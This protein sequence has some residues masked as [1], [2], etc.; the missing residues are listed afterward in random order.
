MNC[1]CNSKDY[2]DFQ[3]AEYDKQNNTILYG[4][5]K[6]MKV[7]GVSDGTCNQINPVIYTNE[8]KCGLGV[9]G[10][11]PCT[12]NNNKSYNDNLDNSNLKNSNEKFETIDNS[13]NISCLELTNSIN[14]IILLLLIYLIYLVVSDYKSKE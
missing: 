10:G 7:L 9:A 3:H 6:N 8:Y 13:N 12:N 2:A 5:N 11:N 4:I 1:G 14:I